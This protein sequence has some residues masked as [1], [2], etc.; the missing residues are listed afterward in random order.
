MLYNLPLQQRI[1]QMY[2]LSSSVPQLHFATKPP[3]R[4]TYTYYFLT[5]VLFSIYFTQDLS[6]RLVVLLI[7]LGFLLP[8]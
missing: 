3:E 7:L 8:F 5:P 4:F 2:I 6:F 1:P